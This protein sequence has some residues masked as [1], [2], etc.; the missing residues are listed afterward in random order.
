M[1]SRPTIKVW[2]LG[3]LFGFG[4]TGCADKLTRENFDRIGIRSADRQEVN[5][6]IGK[7]TAAIENTWMYER[8]DQEITVI[9]EFDENGKVN[10]KRWIPIGGQA[11]EDSKTTPKDRSSRESD[12]IIT[13]EP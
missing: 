4:L 12:T 11:F 9:I 13:R 1:G 6:R 5:E 7:P 10:R 8:P 3:V 2:V